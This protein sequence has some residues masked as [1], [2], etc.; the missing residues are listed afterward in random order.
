MQYLEYTGSR[1]DVPRE[2]PDRDELEDLLRE[3]LHPEFLRRILQ[4][5]GEADYDYLQ[6]QWDLR[7]D[8]I[9]EAAESLEDVEI[10][11]ID[12]V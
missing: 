12:T 5:K 8:E 9:Q 1:Q 6:T 4:W 2:V 11:E 10:K 3:G 7:P